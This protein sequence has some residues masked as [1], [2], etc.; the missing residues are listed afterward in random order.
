MCYK[1]ILRCFFLFDS[2]LDQYKAQEI[3]EIVSCFFISFLIVYFPYKYITQ[4][5]CD[6]AV[7]EFSS[8]IETYS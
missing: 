5:M 7:D 2:I 6:K 4:K 8:S 1:A 3:R